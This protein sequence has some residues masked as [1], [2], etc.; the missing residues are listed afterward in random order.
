MT[1][2][3]PVTGHPADGHQVQLRGAIPLQP[4]QH[5]PGRAA[6][7]RAVLRHPEPCEEGLDRFRWIEK[8]RQSVLHSVIFIENFIYESSLK[9]L[10]YS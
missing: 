8:G 6:D 10:L 7:P 4:V 1:H 2:T 5:Q 9:H 3:F